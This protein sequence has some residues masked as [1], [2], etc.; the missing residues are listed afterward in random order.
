MIRLSTLLR[1]YDANTGM[2]LF[3]IYTLAWGIVTGFGPE[4]YANMF[5]FRHLSMLWPEEAWGVIA[6]LVGLLKLTTLLTPK[7]KWRQ[8]ASLIGFG[9]WLFIAVGFYIADGGTP[10]MAIA[11]LAALAN[12]LT[13]WRLGI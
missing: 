9:F 2:F 3:G 5:A 10:D 7:I 1:R 8:V 11:G 12:L 6:V 13:F 4:T